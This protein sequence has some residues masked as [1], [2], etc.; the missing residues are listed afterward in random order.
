M[1]ATPLQSGHIT[2]G[3]N[4]PSG[5]Q[6]VVAVDNPYITVDDF[7]AT[8]TAQGLGIS[9]TDPLVV[10]GEL[11]NVILQ[12]SAQVNR[13]CNMYFDTQ[14]IDETTTGF[15]VRPYN[16]ELVSVVFNNRPYQ[17]VNSMYIQVLKWF[18]QIDVSDASS[19]LQDFYE[20][21]YCR[22][23]PL[24]SS[25]GQ[26]TGS[27]LPAQIVDHVRLGVLW[28]NYTFGYGTA[29]TGQLL[30]QPSGVSDLKTYQ[31]PVGNR[32]WA[33]SQT[34]NIY[35]NAAL[36]PA[37]AYTIDYINAKIIL[38]T[39]VL[40]TDVITADFTTNQSLPADIIKAVVLLTAH[41]IG[42]DLQ[43]ATGA[44]SYNIQTWSVSYGDENKVEKRAKELLSPYTNRMPK[45]L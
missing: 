3:N 25:A 32:L 22:I 2:T 42:Q 45:F 1:Q 44:Q 41:L 30:G 43:N 8:Y 39:A 27:P 16:P 18:I 6:K 34:V 11:Q 40:N 21:G 23:V 4:T 24:L 14:T 35:K 33:P 12:A 31:S 37:S 36:L 10:S 29:L 28:T 38:T 9:I 17:K 19:Y 26:G 20:D 15:K 5:A 13:L 7:C